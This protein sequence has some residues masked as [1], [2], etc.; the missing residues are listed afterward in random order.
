M[1]DSKWRNFALVVRRA[2]RQPFSVLALGAGLLTTLVTLDGWPFAVSV[3]A[4]L[5]YAAVKLR[6]EGF[7]RAA[8]DEAREGRLRSERRNRTFR[9]EELDIESR[10]KMKA[11]VKLQKEI[12]EDVAN[13][14]VDEVA[15]GLA[16]TVEQT[17]R[18]VDRA[19]AMAQK[20]RELERFLMK[21]EP[22]AIEARIRALESKLSSETDPVRR[23]EAES[24]LAAKKR[25][26]DDY[27][28][29]RQASAR[30]L[31]QLDSIECSFSSLRS[32]LVRIKSSGIDE[33]TAANTELQT[34]LG[35]ISTA[36]GVV[37]QSIE[38]ALQ[39]RGG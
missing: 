10:V 34:E 29:I 7:I 24:A 20:R 21:S 5:V 15:A 9:I 2:L 33:W 32:Q 16:D 26:L 23:S 27:R 6:D 17:E 28:A 18:V 11:I 22:S 3:A 1:P 13:S 35:D 4:V 36:V 14:P 12:A 37:E 39:V 25:E 19:L 38:E 31:D 30:V 8:L